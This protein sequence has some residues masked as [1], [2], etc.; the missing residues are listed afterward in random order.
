MTHP[1]DSQA[2]PLVRAF[3]RKNF[4]PAGT[5][6][7]HRHALGWDLLRAPANVLLAVP[8][9]L[10]RLSI[11]GLT[12]AGCPGIA[13]RLARLRLAF[14][15]ALSREIDRRLRDELLGPLDILPTEGPLRTYADIRNATGEMTATAGTLGAGAVLG[16]LT[17]GVISLSPLIAGAVAQGSAVAAFPLGATLGATWYGLFPPDPGIGLV[18]I[19]V[20]GLMVIFSLVATFSGVLTDPLQSALGLHRWRLMRLVRVLDTI[21]HHADETADLAAPEHGLARSADVAELM[22]TLHRLWRG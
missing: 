4:S 19:S 9:L 5:L 3:I 1:V 14:P 10:L 6:R 8:A 21:A 16:T 17:P 15:T 7:L 13:G 20:I 12:R 11:W 18:C 22:V 2:R